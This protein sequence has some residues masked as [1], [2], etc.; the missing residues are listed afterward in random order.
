MLKKLSYM[1][2]ISF[3][4]AACGG[5]SSSGGSSSTSTSSGQ[6][7][8]SNTAGI[9]YTSGGQSGVTDADGGFAYET[10]GSVTFSVGGVTIGSTDGKSIV[11]PVDLVSGGSSSSAQV[12]N[13]VRFLMMLDDDGDPTDGINIASS[14]QAAAETWSQVDF[15][16]VDLSSE[17][18]SIISDAASADGGTHVLPSASAAKDHLESTL[19]CSYAGAYEGGFSGGDNGN[20]GI[21]VDASTGHV[22][23][24]A[25]SIPDD[26][27]IGLTGTIPISYD[28][29]VTFITG[30]T[31][32]GST[33]TGEFS[34]VNAV[35]GTWSDTVF[36]GN[37]SG[38]RIGGTANAIYRFTGSF[39]GDD[40]GLLS[41]D[42]DSANNIN[43]VIYSI[44]DD[45][46]FTLSG[47]VTGTTLVATTSTGTAVAGT[48]DV[49]TGALSGTWNDSAGGYSGVFLGSGCKLN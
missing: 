24:T 36:F 14:V 5:S 3:A 31:T 1:V 12:Q 41:F 4:L 49:S 46:T 42:V 11:T 19:L 10:G 44:A 33:F 28:Q 32:T 37:F 47:T 18:T 7:K 2:F 23:G 39:S 38:S 34:S 30:N 40:F 35:S 8:D 22:S 13:I 45:L 15:T 6:F 48:L 43:G 20:F 21:L 16:A 9:S 29:Q 26:T 25:Y 27:Y 17:L